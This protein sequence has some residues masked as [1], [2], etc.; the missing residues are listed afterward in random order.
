MPLG[1]RTGNYQALS[2]I[3]PQYRLG[4]VM[5]KAL[6]VLSGGQDSTTCLFWAKSRFDSVFCLTFAYGQLHSNEIDSASKIAQLA[7]VPHEILDVGSIFAGAS[8]L[9]NHDRGV[10]S[11]SSAEDLPGGLEDTFVPGRNILFL[12]LAAN[13]AYV[14]NCDAVVIGVSQEDFG[15]YPDCR[16]EFINH[17]QQAICAGLDRQIEILTPLMDMT[18]KQTVE[19]A[20]TLPG[21]LDA[22][23]ESTT[24]YNG[25]FPPCS[26]CHACLLRE[27]GFREAG[28]PDPLLR[29]TEGSAC[30]K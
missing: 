8:P 14:L 1:A 27:R 24:C 25:C 17:M 10:Q 3:M 11:Y 7:N 12:S 26:T 29:R 23:V 4:D 20:A 16:R 18:K 21:C 13:R 30:K 5:K 22:L 19:L 9:T 2:N 15:G 6:V 28:I